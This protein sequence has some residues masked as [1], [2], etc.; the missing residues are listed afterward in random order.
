MGY[1]C[2]LG[3]SSYSP[4]WL[5]FCCFSLQN[6]LENQPHFWVGGVC[7][8]LCVCV[9]GCVR[10]AQGTRV[11]SFRVSGKPVTTAFATCYSCTRCQKRSQTYKG[12]T[13]PPQRSPLCHC[14]SCS[15]ARE[16]P[17]MPTPPL[18]GSDV[19]EPGGC[20]PPGPPCLWSSVELWNL[21]Q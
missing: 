19:P 8:C 20:S 11:D 3:G 15:D 21:L 12:D 17:R 5:Y 1:P 9:C 10:R 6:V 13:D 16:A 18:R 14:C 7:V 4:E 2:V